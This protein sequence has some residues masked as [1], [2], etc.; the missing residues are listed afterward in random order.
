MRHFIPA[1]LRMS[2]LGACCQSDGAPAV[3]ANVSALS[4]YNFRGA[5]QNAE[6]VIQGD[7][8]VCKPSIMGGRL[9]I[10]SWTNWGAR[11]ETGDSVL[12]DG[13]GRNAKEVYFT[14]SW[15][16][17][18]DSLSGSAGLINYNFPSVAARSTHELNASVGVDTVASPS[19]TNY[20]DFDQVEGRYANL[21]SSHGLEIN[22][23]TNAEFS[24]GVGFTHEDHAA[25]YYGTIKSGLSDALISAGITDTSDEQTTPDSASAWVE[26]SS[27]R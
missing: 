24:A 17:D 23:G 22:E 1:N 2:T 16:K 14:G 15:S 11:D 19:L 5:P 9:D 12:P 26:V 8:N 6:A 10:C 7:M 21:R 3:E 27:K 20:R 4:Q 18:Y 25:T 13:N